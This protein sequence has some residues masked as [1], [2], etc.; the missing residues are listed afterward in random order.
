MGKVTTITPTIA[1]KII[2][3]LEEFEALKKN[4]LLHLP[5]ELIPYGSKLWW[6]KEVLNG[7]KEIKSTTIKTY[8]NAPL[9]LDDLHKGM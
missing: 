6:E 8:K 9:L 7:E 3:E 1:K 2:S 5:Q 4:I